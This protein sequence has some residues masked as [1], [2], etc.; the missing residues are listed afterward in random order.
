MFDVI[1]TNSYILEAV[2]ENCKVLA[3]ADNWLTLAYLEPLL[4]KK[5]NAT[6]NHGERAMRSLHLF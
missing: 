6:I 2:K 1:V 3:T 5:N 4:T